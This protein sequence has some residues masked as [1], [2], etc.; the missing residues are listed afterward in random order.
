MSHYSTRS[1]N[2]VLYLIDA[3]FMYYDMTKNDYSSITL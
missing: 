3:T 1:D 2:Y